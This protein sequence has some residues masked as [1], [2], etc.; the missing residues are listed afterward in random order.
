MKDWTKTGKIKAAVLAAAFLP[1]FVLP[2]PPQPD[3]GMA[4]Y[5]MPFLV[6]AVAVP[7]MAKFNAKA[8]S[9]GLE[10]PRWND[11][12]LKL[13][14]PLSFFHY[15]AWLFVVVGAGMLT[16]T[17]MQFGGLNQMGVVAV[18]FGLGIWL[19]IVFTLRFLTAD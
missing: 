6:G 9:M 13:D 2:D 3:E 8:F 7:F 17:W 1:K 16:G 4:I 11:N 15:G 10:K 14:K 5:Y 19:G 18:G 12:P